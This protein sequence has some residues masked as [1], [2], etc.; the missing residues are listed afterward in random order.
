MKKAGDIISELFRER[1]GPDSLETARSNAGLFSS[2][3]RIA[4]EVWPRRDRTDS[5]PDDVPAAA[6][7]RIRELESGVLLVEA[8][9][10]GWVQLLQTR[11]EELLALVQRRYPKLGIR[12]IAFMLSREP[13]TIE[14]PKPD[15]HAVTADDILPEPAQGRPPAQ[16]GN[17]FENIQPDSVFDSAVPSPRHEELY[18]ALKGLEESVKKRNK[19][20]P[21]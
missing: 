9:H 1:F 7:S 11:Q 2:W 12:A 5:L 6:H 21:L 20:V 17:G 16:N 3:T 14:Y 18:A 8:D 13:F 4:A 15:N 10:P 19:H